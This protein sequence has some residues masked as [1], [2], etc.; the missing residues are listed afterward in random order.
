MCQVRPL[1]AGSLHLVSVVPVESFLV[2]HV[3][4]ASFPFSERIRSS[5][6]E[7]DKWTDL[8]ACNEPFCNTFAYLRAHTRWVS[9]SPS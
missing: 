9:S 6:E 7:D 8:C 3:A 5:R 2:N 4:C 1:L